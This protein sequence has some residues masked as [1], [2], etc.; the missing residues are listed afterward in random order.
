MANESK[1]GGPVNTR[2][3][4]PPQWAERLLERLLPARDRQTIIGDLREEYLEEILPCSGPLRANL[5]YLRQLASLTARSLAERGNPR[6]A[7]LAISAWTFI[8]G[9]WLAWME[10]VLQH[11]GYRARLS[12]ALGVAFIALATVLARVFHLGFRRERWLWAGAAAL[13][14]LGSYAFLRNLLASHFEGFVFL[15]SLSFIVQGVLM[16]LSLG[17]PDLNQRLD[18]RVDRNSGPQPPQRKSAP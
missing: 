12:I 14:A 10:S 6:R 5:W 18:Q 4:A 3:A 15:L 11:P 7:L 17:R 2:P 1:K 13:I 16:L 8:C 9:S